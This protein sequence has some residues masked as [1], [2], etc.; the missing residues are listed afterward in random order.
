ML[1]TQMQKATGAVQNMLQNIS[2]GQS[3]WK[4]KSFSPE[5]RELVIQKNGQEI[6][7]SA[8]DVLQESNRRH[9]KRSLKMTSNGL[10]LS[11]MTDEEF[12]DIADAATLKEEWHAD[13][14]YVQNT[15]ESDALV[16]GLAL[17]EV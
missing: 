2:G 8:D 13:A 16:S 4:P 1:K 12:A 15:K 9:F 7:I 3:E 11:S 6:T 5:T 17:E 10:F 14:Q